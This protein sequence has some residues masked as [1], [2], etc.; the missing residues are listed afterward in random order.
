MNNKHEGIKDL[1]GREPIGAHVTIGKK[2][3]RGFPQERDRWHI[4][5][6]RGADGIK[7]YH[8]AF[9]VFN[10]A[11]AEKRKVLRGVLVHSSQSECFEHYL[12]AQLIHTPAHPNMH[13][14][15]IGDGKT[16]T[17]WSFN[18]ADEFDEIACPH[19]KCEFRQPVSNTQGA[20]CKPWGM[21]LFRLRWQE[22]VSMPT[23]LVKYS[24]GSWNTVANLKGFFEHMANAARNLGIEDPKLFGM[25]FLLTLQEQ[26]S[27]AKKS[28]FPVV[29]ITP[30]IDPFEFFMNQRENMK[31][32]Q[33]TELVTLPDLTTEERFE[34]QQAISVPTEVK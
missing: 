16:A 18:G 17:R 34:D 2:Q 7:A 13:P 25:P 9:N 5:N 19:E 30:E 4:V 26:T 29:H 6:P 23:P 22:G 1:Q 14:Q 12:K 33:D 27:A 24:T 31:L 3:A 32:M 11:A 20:P 21:L 8:P 10:T 28:R 15:C